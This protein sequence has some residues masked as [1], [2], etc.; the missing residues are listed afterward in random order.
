MNL[1]VTEKTA[2]R[3][4]LGEEVYE[5]LSGRA[6]K[7][8]TGRTYKL[9]NIPN[10]FVKVLSNCNMDVEQ[11]P[12][13]VWG[14]I[15]PKCSHE[16]YIESRCGIPTRKVY[17]VKLA[18]T[19]KHGSM[20]KAWLRG[21]LDSGLFISKNLCVEMRG[22]VASAEPYCELCE[23]Y[24][25]WYR[26]FLATR[27]NVG[28]DKLYTIKGWTNRRYTNGCFMPKR[29]KIVG[30]RDCRVSEITEEEWKLLGADDTERSRMDV[31][32]KDYW[33]RN[34]HI[35]LYRYELVTNNALKNEEW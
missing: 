9:G 19:Q 24:G 1:V 8:Y 34:F 35:R 2:S 15:S 33:T 5:I 17:V 21:G 3:L 20:Q 25:D 28:L 12:S 32:G 18:L 27:Y 13:K 7:F 22:E 26:T 11:I 4:M 6:Y 31:V 30:Y 23:E 16:E 29:V 14:D 10:T